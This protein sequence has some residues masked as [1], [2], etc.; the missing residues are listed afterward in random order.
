[1][2]HA[3]ATEF[4]AD[5]GHET[6]AQFAIVGLHPHF[7]QRVRGERDVDLMQHG[8]GEP[9][10]ADHHDGIKVMR[11]SAK[12]ATGGRGESRLTCHAAI[13]SRYKQNGG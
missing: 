3:L 7:N 12:R 8:R 13:I 10:V 11:G 6:H 1:M 4:C 5:L 9:F 2:L